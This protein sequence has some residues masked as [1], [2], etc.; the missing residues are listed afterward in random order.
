M[1]DLHGEPTEELITA[2]KAEQPDLIAIP[3]DLCTIDEP[4][5]RVVDPV[6]Y[7]RRLQELV[8][9]QEKVQVKSG[10]FIYSSAH[11]LV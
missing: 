7:E 5:G 8:L 10:K 1:A 11:L 6:K 9:C 4:E 3:G 2:L